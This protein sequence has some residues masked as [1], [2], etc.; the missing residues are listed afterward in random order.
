MVY[1][2]TFTVYIYKTKQNKTL[3]DLELPY[4]KKSRKSQLKSYRLFSLCHSWCLPPSCYI[5]KC[6]RSSYRRPALPPSMTCR[7]PTLLVLSRT[8]FAWPCLVLESDDTLSVLNHW[9]WHTNTIITN[10]EKPSLDAKNPLTSISCGVSLWLENFLRAVYSHKTHSFLPSRNLCKRGFQQQQPTTL[11]PPSTFFFTLDST[12]LLPTDHTTF[13]FRHST[14]IYAATI[15]H[16]ENKNCS[17]LLIVNHSSHT[18]MEWHV[19]SVERKNLP[20]PNSISSEQ[21]ILPQLFT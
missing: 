4:P 21:V 11:S 17:R 5:R 18:T 12:H 2:D 3:K 10:L 19:L 15:M 16:Q 8:S 7:W 9:F 20:T 13:F 1:Y 14:N 6:N